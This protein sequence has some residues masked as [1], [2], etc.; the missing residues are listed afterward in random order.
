M[1]ML[2]TSRANRRD[3]VSRL[4]PVSRETGVGHLHARYGAGGNCTGPH[5]STCRIPAHAVDFR[6]RC[7]C[8]PQLAQFRA[9]LLVESVRGGVGRWNLGVG[10]GI[11]GV[12]RM[13]S[14][15][16]APCHFP[17]GRG[18][19]D[20]GQA[21]ANPRSGAGPVEHRRRGG[22]SPQV[23]GISTMDILSP[24]IRSR[25]ALS[26]PAQWILAHAGSRRIS[27]IQR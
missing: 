1:V 12:C 7:S 18:L 8:T 13:G 11:A 5:V 20:A 24:S 15:F 3:P 9:R 26:T 19:D 14:R 21:T 6:Y 16:S 22:Y 23:T 27:P 10:G 4:G 2:D 17:R 25:G